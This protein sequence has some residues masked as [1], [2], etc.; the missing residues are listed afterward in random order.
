[1]EQTLGKRIMQCRKSLGLTQ[2]QLAEKLGVTAQAVSKWENDLSCPDISVLPK[3]AGIFGITT[4]ALL[5]NTTAEPVHQGEVVDENAQDQDGI[6]IQNGS[7]EFHYDNSK[8]SALG[9][10]LF[11]LA[12]GAQLLAGKL[13]L[14]DLSFWGILWPT[15]LFVWGIFGCLSKFSFFHIGCLLVGSYFMLDNWELLSFTMSSE[16]VF[17]AIIVLFGICL[18]VEAFKKPNKPRFRFLHKDKQTADYQVNGD[19]FA[20]EASFG[21]AD[22]LVSIPRLAYG[23]I[24]TSFGDYDIDLRE[25]EELSDDCH[26]DMNCSFGDLTLYVPRRYAVKPVTSTSFAEFSVEG[27]P[28][29]APAGIINVRANV[30]FGEITIE[31]I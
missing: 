12:V 25:V 23:K 24:S 13:L 7:W 30:S 22:Q 3:L 31:Y 17:P 19:S 18:L 9:F 29:S 10:A 27:H 6:H 20:F 26:L 28:D 21:E 16:L 2:D 5:G 14:K 11:V 1:M 8:K 15:A 4:D